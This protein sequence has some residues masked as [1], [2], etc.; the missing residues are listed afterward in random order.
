MTSIFEEF[1]SGRA[2][3]TGGIATAAV[4]VGIIAL[5]LSFVTG[6]AR[7]GLGA[8]AAA[9]LYAAGIAAG[10]VA[11]SAAVRAVGGRWALPVLPIAEGPAGF[12]VPGLIPLLVIVVTAGIWMPAQAMTGSG[13]L[14]LTARE[15]VMTAVL[16]IAA[17]F[18]ISRSRALALEREGAGFQAVVYLLL[19][20]VSLTL[21]TMDLAMAPAPGAPSTV[22]PALYFMGAFL[23]GIAWVAFAGSVRG[24]IADQGVRRDLGNMLFAFAAFWVYLLWSSYLP[25]WYENLPDETAFLLA[26]WA[27]AWRVLTALM[28]LAVFAV[29]FFLYL[30]ESAVRNRAA[31]AAGSG[32]VLAGLLLE[33]VLLVFPSRSLPGGGWSILLAAGV[34]GGVLGLFVLSVRIGPAAAVSGPE[35]AGTRR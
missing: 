15:V 13:V 8:L 24:G 3:R 10:G 34:I 5:V 32:T 6:E 4:V 17:R 20:A 2:R 19:Y 25:V 14:L 12:L 22:L 16:V 21:W 33:T 27:G 9:W 18:Y 23:G 31:L 7:T 1:R 28:V 30:P 11:V 29:P 26:R 35:P